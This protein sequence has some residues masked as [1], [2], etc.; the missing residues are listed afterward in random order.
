MA[1]NNVIVFPKQSKFNIAV[2]IILAVLVYMAVCIYSFFSKEHIVSYEV[3]EGVLVDDSRYEA[4]IIRNEQ[5]VNSKAAGYVNYFM[6]EREKVGVGNLVYT[7]DESGTILDYMEALEAGDNSL[8]TAVMDEFRDTLDDFVQKYDREDLTSL[9]QL[10]NSLRNQTQK[11]ANTQLLSKLSSASSLNGL[12]QYYRADQ[13]GNLVYWK[14]GLENLQLSEVTA[15]LFKKE[16]YAVTYM[17]GNQLVTAGDAVYKL[18]DSEKWSIAF[19]MEDKEKAQKYLEEEVLEVRFLKNDIKLWGTVSLLQNTAGETVVALAFQSGSI[20]FA[21]DR[22]VEIEIG[23]EDETGL[24]I[25]VSAI[26]QKEFFLVPQEYVAYVEEERAYYIYIETYMENGTKTIQK[27]EVSPASLKEEQYYLD[28][29]KL[30][31]GTRLAKLNSSDVYTVSQKGALTGVY[32]INKGYADFKQ[33]TVKDQN[34]SYAIVASNTQYG[35][36]VYDYIV[37]N[38]SAVSENDFVY[39]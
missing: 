18:Y 13:A 38:A 25:P 27:H 3:R 21:T 15:K 10:N 9:Y 31:V 28:D 5:L 29:V 20:N 30:S 39:D 33:I 6:A 1:R 22:F 16:E 23:M 2:I 17:M 19:V 12:V 11:I 14:D 35:L 36:N 4:V 34:A 8:G 7:L 37:L 26:A 24:K 32:N